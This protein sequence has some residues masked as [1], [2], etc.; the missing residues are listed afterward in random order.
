VHTPQGRY[1]DDV[2]T[3]TEVEGVH[4]PQGRY[5]DDVPTT[6]EVERV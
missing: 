1:V 5:V 3:T 6:T 4:T 2:L